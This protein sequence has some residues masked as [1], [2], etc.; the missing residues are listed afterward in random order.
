MIATKIYSFIFDIEIPLETLGDNIM[1]RTLGEMTFFGLFFV[2]L[3]SFF[4][5]MLDSWSV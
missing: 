4:L 3:L 1:P 5:L 2:E